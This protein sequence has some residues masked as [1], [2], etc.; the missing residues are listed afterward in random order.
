MLEQKQFQVVLAHCGVK[1]EEHRWA[2]HILKKRFPDL[3]LR[4]ACPVLNHPIDKDKG[5]K[6][7]WPIFATQKDIRDRLSEKTQFQKL[8][9]VSASVYQTLSETE[10]ISVTWIPN[11]FNYQDLILQ[12]NNWV[13]KNL[14]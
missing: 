4:I 13:E 9:V 3:E 2:T 14:H 7:H 8:I 12:I 6:S 5:I 1:P 11:R 10:K